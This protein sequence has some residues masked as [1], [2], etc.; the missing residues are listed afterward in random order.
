MARMAR[1]EAAR[2][3]HFAGG[4]QTAAEFADECFYLDPVSNAR[5]L[6]RSRRTAPIV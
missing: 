5:P 2:A 4:K 6:C 3:K 1:G